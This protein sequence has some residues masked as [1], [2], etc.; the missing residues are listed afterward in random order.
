MDLG[1]YAVLTGE[2][3]FTTAD[4]TSVSLATYWPDATGTFPTVIFGHGF[5]LS[6]DLYVSYGEHLASWGFVVVMP[7]YPGNMFSPT[8]HRTLKEYSMELID[9]LEGQPGA[10]AGKVDAGKI[11]M[12]GH[13][14]GGKVAILTSTEDSRVRALFGIDPVDTTGGGPMGGGPTPENPS[15]TPELMNLI[16]IP[17]VSLGETH[18]G[19]GGLFGQACAPT[20]DNYQ[21]YYLHAEGPA[22]EITMVGASHMSF[23]DNPNCGITCSVCSAGTDDT[24]MTRALT[25]RYLAAFFLSTLGDD[26]GYQS[27]LMGS[28]MDQ[29]VA[30]GYVTYTTK[31]GFGL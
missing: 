11:G 13:S 31:N 19:D 8:D 23:L 1:D 29:D 2:E 30:D 15:V 3:S 4:G 28:A 21:Q 10:L 5:M 24:D 17:F 14:L 7:E 22:L 26:R 6:T 25:Q 27:L 18:S 12:T 9:W 20:E 16:D